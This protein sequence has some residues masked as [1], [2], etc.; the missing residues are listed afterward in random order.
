MSA[1]EYQESLN[2]RLR[3]LTLTQAPDPWRLVASIAVGGFEALGF[4][5]DSRYL[6]LVTSSGRGVFN[7]ES[8][9]RLERERSSGE[10]E[11]YDLET[12][13]VKGIGP[14]AGQSI[15]VAGIH[16]GGLPRVTLDGWVADLLSPGWPSSF[17]TLSPPGSSPWFPDQAEKVAKV[18]PTSGDEA[19]KCYGFS[20]S[21]RH[22]VVATSHTIDL[23]AR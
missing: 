3:A 20:W 13:E 15:R 7:A 21:R 10:G 23:F 2:S 4:S 14:V 1:D 17:V 19:V 22:L 18:A 12:L 16:G 5:T 6:L 11:W 8:G 9:Q